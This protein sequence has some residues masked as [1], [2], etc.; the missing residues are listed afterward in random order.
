MKKRLRLE[1]IDFGV[2]RWVLLIGPWAIKIPKNFRGWLANQSEWRQRKR[3]D[4]ARP[5]LTLVHFLVVFPRADEIGRWG[6]EDFV[7][8]HEYS[9]EES[10][11]SSW[12]KFGGVWMLI[13]YDRAWQHP[14]SLI[15]WP[16][17][18]NQERL[19]RKWSKLPT[20]HYTCSGC[21][22]CKVGKDEWRFVTLE[23]INEQ[24]EL[25]WMDIHPEDFCHRCGMRNCCWSASKEEW[26]IATKK[27]A[28]E[29]GREGI[30]CP[31]CFM[32]M[33]EEATG[34]KANV[35]VQVWR[36]S[37]SKYGNGP[38]LTT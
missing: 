32:E 37:W 31:Q 25:G 36:G 1:W 26:D 12:G 30:C 33:Y 15:A 7:R 3:I 5:K 2:T 20:N 6:P 13:D 38:M 34:K 35:V 17:Y 16:Y 4:V 19:S 11:G 10:K 8:R 21:P 14:R 18:W 28:E 23:Y 9:L 24:R 22:A 27:W 29:T